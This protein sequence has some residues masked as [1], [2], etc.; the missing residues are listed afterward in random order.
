M[1]IHQVAQQSVDWMILRSGKPTASE[2]DNL[3]S[4]TWKVRTG[5]TPKSYLAAKLAEAWL[6]GPLITFNTFDMDQGNLIESEARPWLALELN[7]DIKQVGFI[8]DDSERIGCSPDGIA[9]EVGVEIKSPQPTQHVKNLLNGAVPPEHL[10][11][12]HGGM[13]VTGFQ[14]WIYCSYRRNFPNLVLRIKRD[15]EIQD[16]ISA[17]LDEFLTRFDLAMARL[18]EINGGPPRRKP[19]PRVNQ[20]PEPFLSETPT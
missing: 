19:L 15:Q 18:E 10:A 9:G 11:Q 1:I 6:G 13:F 4:P 5:E 8:T 12:V 3:I 2:F 17:A 16:Q 7:I 20:E 14:E